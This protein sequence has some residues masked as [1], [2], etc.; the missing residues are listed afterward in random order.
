VLLSFRSDGLVANTTF[1]EVFGG[2]FQDLVRKKIVCG[3]VAFL[4]VFLPFLVCFVVVNR[5]EFVV[6][7]V[8][9]VVC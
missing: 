9:N 6:E 5:G 2:D 7:C 1:G 3:G 8:A 4:L